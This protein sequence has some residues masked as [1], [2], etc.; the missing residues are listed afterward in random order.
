MN[1]I[2]N[3][4]LSTLVGLFVLLAAVGAVLVASLAIAAIHQPLAHALAVAAVLLF[5]G[6]A[7]VGSV[8]L[9]TRFAV[10]LFAGESWPSHL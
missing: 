1:R 2:A 9:A 10:W 7:L 5:G 8:Y 3:T 4:I 6:G